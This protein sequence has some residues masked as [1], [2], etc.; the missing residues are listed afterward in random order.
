M[1]P[2]AATVMNAI[3]ENVPSSPGRWSASS[4][5]VAFL[6]ALSCNAILLFAI[7]D[8]FWWAPDDGY[9]AHIARRLLNGEVLF[10]DIEDFHLGLVH[11]VNALSMLL[12]GETLLS[13]RYPL[14]V[15]ALA[16]SMIVHAL[17]AGRSLPLAIVASLAVSAVGLP[18]FQNPSAN[19]YVLF[20]AFVAALLLQTRNHRKTS[21][22]FTLG[23]LVGIAFLFRHLTAA[24]LGMAVLVTLLARADPHASEDGATGGQWLARSTI[25]ALAGIL[26]A[27]GLPR[28][29]PFTGPAFL[30]GPMAVLICVFRGPLTG[31]RATARILI[32][33][34]AGLATAFLPLLVYLA[35]NAALDDCFRVLL[36]MSRALLAMPFLDNPRY[37]HVVLYGL[38]QFLRSPSLPVFLNAGYWLSL[39]LLPGIIAFALVRRGWR[40]TAA[41]LATPIATVALFVGVAALH[42]Q[43]PIYLSFV[44]PLLVAGTAMLASGRSV[45]AH[46]IT[47]SWLV[48]LAFTGFHWQ[49]SLPIPSRAL[50]VLFSASEWPTDEVRLDGRARIVIDRKEAETH[51]R[52]LDLI[53][54]NSAPGDAILSMPAIPEFYF[55]ADRRNP[56]PFANV[57][58]GTFRRLAEVTQRLESDPPAL[59]INRR[60][61]KYHNSDTALLL[62][63]IRAR[64]RLLQ[65]VGEFDVYVAG[66][67]PVGRAPPERDKADGL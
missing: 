3:E 34:S 2:P 60:V 59:V 33:T 6:I 45:I 55:L 41:M 7:F 67:A 9:Y 49:S 17:I 36:G 22:L 39:L 21:V 48:L 16:Q 28:L 13:M 52:L 63:W 61:D 57:G 37:Y 10:R 29:D 24:F 5:A 12:F 66:G 54:R 40:S 14:V 58:L 65:S 44:A 64:Y 50:S 31:N 11:L 35:M 26:L 27:Y 43:I 46:S 38:I 53:G 8:H 19:W 23:L 4:P 18:Q 47:G 15:V 56:L 20:I 62:E 51:T 42:Y 32:V 30:A 25:L 1:T